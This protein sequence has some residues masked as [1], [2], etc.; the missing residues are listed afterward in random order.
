MPVNHSEPDSY[1][2]TDEVDF[3]EIQYREIIRI[4]KARYEFSSFTE[5][6]WGRRFVLWRHDVDFSLNRAMSLARIESEMG[7]FATYFF[8]LHSSY[9][10]VLEREQSALVKSVLGLGHQVG[11]HFD[12][13]FYDIRAEHDLGEFLLREREVFELLLG[14]SP[15]AFSFH[16]PT[17]LELAWGEDSYAGLV[18]CYSRTL[19]S[20][21]S[22]CSDSNGYWRHRRLI[23]VLSDGDEDGIHVLT[24]PEHWQIESLKPR[25]RVS[26]SIYGRADRCMRLYDET[27]E[28]SGR[29]N[30]SDIPECILKLAREDPVTSGCLSHLW[31]SGLYWAVVVELLRQI[32]PVS[33]RISE[34]GFGTKQAEEPA[35]DS[36]KRGVAAGLLEGE[37]FSNDTLKAWAVTLSE[38][39]LARAPSWAKS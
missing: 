36:V 5:I 18:N 33:L 35:L 32:E 39:V 15:A 22:Y 20:K 13:S 28:R 17:E 21:V 31:S 24:H 34:P 29:V 12:T 9:Y 16:N 7:V 10:N 11:I 1:R 37:A 6:P 3:T 19:R 8:D 23:D 2:T 4:A 30:A 27:L 26:R 38:A 14:C 25:E